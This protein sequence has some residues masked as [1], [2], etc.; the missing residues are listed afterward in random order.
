MYVFTIKARN[1]CQCCSVVLMALFVVL[2]ACVCVFVSSVNYLHNWQ[3]LSIV[4]DGNGK[5]VSLRLVLQWKFDSAPSSS[6]VW[7]AVW[8]TCVEQFS[9]RAHFDKTTPGE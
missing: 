7:G 8:R 9:R 6:E 4:D 3:Y 2:D 1:Q 5:Y